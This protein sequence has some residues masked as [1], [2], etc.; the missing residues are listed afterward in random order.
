[1]YGCF[2]RNLLG[3]NYVI[4]IELTQRK[5]VP[6]LRCVFHWV[7]K[8]FEGFCLK[9]VNSLFTLASD[10]NRCLSACFSGSEIGS[11]RRRH[12]GCMPDASVASNTCRTLVLMVSAVWGHALIKQLLALVFYLCF[13]LRNIAFIHQWISSC[14]H[15]SVFK[16]ESQHT[17]LVGCIWNIICHTF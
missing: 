14:W 2:N 5:S 10:W 15:T 13:W 4:S 1:M 7:T 3:I 11:H 17:D 9:V 12:P 6:K 16:L 8:N